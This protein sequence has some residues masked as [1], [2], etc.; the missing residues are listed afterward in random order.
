MISRVE[1]E[2][3]MNWAEQHPALFVKAF[4]K[5]KE[6]YPTSDWLIK[7]DMTRKS[8]VTLVAITKII[9]DQ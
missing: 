8:Y 6:D 3:N 1:V 4:S 7:I 5:F 2:M 9:G